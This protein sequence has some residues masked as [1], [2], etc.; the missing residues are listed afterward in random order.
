MCL[1]HGGNPKPGDPKPEGY[2]LEYEWAEVQLRAGLEQV[3]CG[4]CSKYKF[5]Q[6]LSG[7]VD[8]TPAFDRRGKTHL[9][10]SPV[11]LG[12]EGVGDG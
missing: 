10:R 5:P 3:R 2:S 8:V 6:E 11:C 7:L 4:R 9:I 1:L 12:C